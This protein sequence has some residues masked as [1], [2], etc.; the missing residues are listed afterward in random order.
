VRFEKIGT[1]II[2]IGTAL[3][4]AVSASAALGQTTAASQSE[5][6]TP[7]APPIVAGLDLSAIDRR[8]DAC[9]DFCQ[10]AYGNW[11]I[12]FPRARCAGFARSRSFRSA[13]CMNFGR[14]WPE[15]PRS[16]RAH[17]RRSMAISLQRAWTSRSCRRRASSRSS[18]RS[19]A[20]PL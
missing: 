11:T 10:Y 20:L 19:I 15:P 2:R 4:F 18:R 8:A 3:V 16:L 13:T 17:S 6:E 5:A 14:N 1:K 7:K 12:R 9:A